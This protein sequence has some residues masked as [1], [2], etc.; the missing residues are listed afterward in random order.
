MNILDALFFLAHQARHA[1]LRTHMRLQ[2]KHA[3]ARL[4]RGQAKRI[5]AGKRA[6]MP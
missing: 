1:R 4:Q 3:T 2:G 6:Y 5:H